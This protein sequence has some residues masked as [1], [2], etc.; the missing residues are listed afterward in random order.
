[1][2]QY[3]RLARAERAS[4]KISDE[5]YLSVNV[6]EAHLAHACA[7]SASTGAATWRAVVA[8]WLITEDSPCRRSVNDCEPA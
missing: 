8:G 1:L 7:G 4:R 6:V 3:T 2:A 5:L